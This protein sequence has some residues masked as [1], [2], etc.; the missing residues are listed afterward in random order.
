MDKK[1]ILTLMLVLFITMSCKEHTRKG[2][3]STLAIK[4]KLWTESE[5][6][7]L[8]EGLKRTENDLIHEVE[9]LNEDQ[10]NFHESPERWSIREIVEHLEIQDEM[11]YRELY[12]IS[13]TPILPEYVDLVKGN[14]SKILEYATD[15]TPGN[16]G[17]LLAPIGRFCDKPSSIKAFERIRGEVIKFVEESNQDFRLHFTFRK[18]PEDGS[19]SDP[20]LWDIRDLHQLLLTTIAHTDRHIGQIRKVKDHPDYPN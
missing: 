7:L 11:Y 2:D 10:W 19:L 8:I 20:G 3:Q 17:W 5:R 15:P 12:I 14:D 4:D 18:Y 13:K 6:Q 1:Q 16:S 9:N